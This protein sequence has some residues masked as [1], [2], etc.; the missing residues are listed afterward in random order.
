MKNILLLVH[1][2]VGQESRLQAG[3][4]ITRALGGHLI[5]LNVA[6]LPTVS[7]QFY[8]VG[9]VGVLIA[10]NE[11]A[12]EASNRRNIEGRLAREDVP[13]TWLETAG[14]VTVAISDAADMADIVIVNLHLGDSAGLDARRIAA[15]LVVRLRKP[16]VAVPEEACGF[17]AAGAAM[18]AWDGSA[19]S[20][21]ALRAAVPL[22]RLA[23]TVTLVTVT[24]DATS[25][26]PAEEG[27]AYLSRHG[28][29]ALVVR[30]RN[31]GIATARTLLGEAGDAEASYIVMGGFGRRRLVEAIFGGVSQDVL[32]SSSIPVVM[33]H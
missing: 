33:V 13:W 8:S 18:I 1:D 2:D 7:R 4:D 16:V 5:C 6:S 32:S 3:L 20:T 27:A 14:D 26:T 25:G 22:L 9:A 19:E 30:R 29:K 31:R 12:S 15:E 17:D 21:N 23:D 11:I 28:V 10:E 24:D